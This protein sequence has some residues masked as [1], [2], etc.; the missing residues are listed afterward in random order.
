[1]LLGRVVDAD[2]NVPVSQARVRVRAGRSQV[3]TGQLV[4]QPAL[5]QGQVALETGRDGR[6]VVRDAPVPALTVSVEAPGYLPLPARTHVVAPGLRVS[7]VTVRL[8][9]S[10]SVSGQ[11]TDEW[12]EPLVRV[13]V[14]AW[15]RTW[16]RGVPRWTQVLTAGLPSTDDR[17]RY[18][19]GQLPPGD[20]LVGAPH[21]QT[22]APV[23]TQERLLGALAGGQAEQMMESAMG[24]VFSDSPIVPVGLRVRD[25]LVASSSGALPMPTAGG[26]WMVMPTTL[27]PGVQS[28]SA[29]QVVTITAGEQRVGVDFSIPLVPAVSVSGVVTGAA[30]S[31]AGMGVRLRP[32]DDGGSAD[33]TFDVAHTAARADGTFVVPMVPEGRYVATAVQV[34]AP[35]SLADMMAGRRPAD[36]ATGPTLFARVPVSVEKD[37]ADVVLALSAGPRV[38]G[39]VVVPTSAA[40]VALDKARVSVTP[41]DQSE[42]QVMRSSLSLGA[43]AADGTFEVA[44]GPPGRYVIAVSG[45]PPTWFAR[46]A[47]WSNRNLI[48]QAT[49]FES[50]DVLGVEIVLA[51]TPASITGTVVGAGDTTVLAFPEDWRTWFA[52]GMSPLLLRQAPVSETGAFTLASVPA[53]RYLLVALAP[54]ALGDLQDPAVFERL[55]S[56]GTS[57][58]VA[59]GQA[60]T[61]A[62]RRTEGR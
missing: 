29:A 13:P 23:A 22:S 54:D 25:S 44:V 21:T 3:T 5:P 41:I 47:M 6:F 39:R 58:T 10:A 35:Q 2:T 50:D 60:L 48:F 56:L 1:V 12:G 31:T 9:R 40:A 4:T 24:A 59:D 34:P 61:V 43:V 33:A 38:R 52:D 11:V 27:F 28:V 37:V 42:L 36:A 55:A 8:T 45:L 53:G 20:Y 62:L 7:E 49:R 57:T 15:R 16:S 17:G 19:I 30:G 46:S 32:A 26:R 18:T 51:E 14:R